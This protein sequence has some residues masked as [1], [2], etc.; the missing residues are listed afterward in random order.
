MTDGGT[1][2]VAADKLPKINYVSPQVDENY[3]LS[4][5]PGYQVSSLADLSSNIEPEPSLSFVDGD[6]VRLQ[7]PV[8]GVFLPP[9][10][11]IVVVI[12]NHC[13]HTTTKIS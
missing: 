4:D 9:V 5:I 3:T 12:V 6:D 1:F 8:T 2:V 11:V 10:V 7:N 13:C